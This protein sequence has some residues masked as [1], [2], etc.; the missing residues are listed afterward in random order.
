MMPP[1]SIPLPGLQWIP[2]VNAVEVQQSSGLSIDAKT[3]NYT[4]YTTI[5]VSAADLWK[6]VNGLLGLTNDRVRSQS[7][8][9]FVVGARTPT[10]VRTHRGSRKVKYIFRN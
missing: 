3:L 2:G 10:W 8:S 9:N 4:T 5:D 1:A 7:G 6:A